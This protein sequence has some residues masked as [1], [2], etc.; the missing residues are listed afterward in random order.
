MNIYIKISKMHYFISY[1][2]TGVELV[3]LH[4]FIDPVVEIIKSYGHSVFCNLYY[5]DMYTQGKYTIKQIFDH[6]FENIKKCDVYVA[7]I[8]DAFGGGMAIECGYAICHGK[9]II[10]CQPSN[11]K[12]N[13]SLESLSECVIK[14]D[15][16]ED[17]HKNLK[18]YF[19]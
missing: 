7:L 13:N 19:E 15:S 3:K 16:I 18:K 5:G 17:M 9:R 14:Y 10:A 6:C 1:K 12:N 8:D 4:E 11:L 2:F